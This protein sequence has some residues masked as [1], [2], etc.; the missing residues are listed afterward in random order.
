L[1]TVRFGSAGWT[2]G[3]NSGKLEASAGFPGGWAWEPARLSLNTGVATLELVKTGFLRL[4][5]ERLPVIFS[6]IQAKKVSGRD[7]LVLLVCLHFTSWKTGKCRVATKKIS[8]LLGTAL[9]N[10][11]GSM[12]RLKACGLITDAVDTSGI[13]YMIPHPK[14]FECSAGKAR[15]LLLKNYYAGVYGQ[16]YELSIQD[17]ELE[18]LEAKPSASHLTDSHPDGDDLEDSSYYDEL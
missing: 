18:F 12:R 6:L 5:N 14:L 7:I 10:V 13:P 2:L 9:P 17:E 8:E 15:G 11:R 1:K 4:M 3:D 16:N